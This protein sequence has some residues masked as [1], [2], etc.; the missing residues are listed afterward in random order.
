MHK[1]AEYALAVVVR[2]NTTDTMM[3]TI[4]HAV[5]IADIILDRIKGAT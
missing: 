5:P 3:A 2:K 4:K 1:T